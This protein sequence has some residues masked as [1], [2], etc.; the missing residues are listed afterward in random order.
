MVIYLK[1]PLFF[2]ISCFLEAILWKCVLYR[3]NAF[4]LVS[5][6]PSHLSIPYTAHPK[7]SQ[8][9]FDPRMRSH[10]RSAWGNVVLGRLVED[11]PISLSVLGSLAQDQLAQWSAWVGTRIFADKT[12]DR[13]RWDAERRHGKRAHTAVCSGP[14][15]PPLHL[16]HWWPTE[17]SNGTTL[18]TSPLA[19]KPGLHEVVSLLAAVCSFQLIA[20]VSLLREPGIF[21]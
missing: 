18:G 14:P 15:P 3:D 7:I 17:P 19:H 2:A 4:I 13:T 9:E 16:L 20:F 1:S 11:L 6:F 10:Y 21:F 5:A 12:T 8:L